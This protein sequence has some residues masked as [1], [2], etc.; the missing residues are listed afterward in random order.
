MRRFN[1]EEL[2]ELLDTTLFELEE[3]G[4]STVV[5]WPQANRLYKLIRTAEACGMRREVIIV[6]VTRW[7]YQHGQLYELD[8]ALQRAGWKR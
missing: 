6:L 2:I 7:C 8:K 3:E 4:V 5:S 1:R